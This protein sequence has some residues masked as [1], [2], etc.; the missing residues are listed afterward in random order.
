M[1]PST[2]LYIGEQGLR[3]N[4]CIYKERNKGDDKYLGVYNNTYFSKSKIFFSIEDAK[5]WL[6]AYALTV[7]DPKK[8]PPPDD[9]NF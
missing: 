5:V 6:D 7:T 2:N 3:K 9:Y 1:K 8:K 4:K